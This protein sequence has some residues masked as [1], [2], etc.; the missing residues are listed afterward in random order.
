MLLELAG[1]AGSPLMSPPY[2]T[3][4]GNGAIKVS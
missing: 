2:S 3:N 4:V 1:R